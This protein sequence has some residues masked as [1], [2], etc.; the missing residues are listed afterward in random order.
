MKTKD[1]M[2]IFFG[3]VL[4]CFF[5]AV[6]IGAYQYNTKARLMPL[7]IAFP[8]I[9][10]ASIQL[11]SVLRGK[12]K[13]KVISIEDEMFQKTMDKIHVEVMEEK[14]VKRTDREEAIALLKAAG[15]VMLYVLM[16][17]LFGFLI[18]IPV[19][20]VIFMRSQDDGWVASVS[21]A[22]GLWATI[23][24]VFVVIAKISLYDALIFRLLATGE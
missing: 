7:V 12:K 18:T 13:K 6:I 10:M 5:L 21:T 20:T 17:Y 8:C 24:L 23:Y 15:W 19:F 4:I 11:V 9:I 1:K 22:F 16:V 14:K 2:E 3:S